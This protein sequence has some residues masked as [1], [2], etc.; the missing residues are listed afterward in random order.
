MPEK[1]FYLLIIFSVVTVLMLIKLAAARIGR[2]R[3]GRRFER[4]IA[5]H[6]RKRAAGQL[7]KNRVKSMLR[8][9][10]YDHRMITDGW[11]S[12]TL[13]TMKS[14]RDC[15]KRTSGKEKKG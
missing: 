12:I 9:I 11:I 2:H 6:L 3:K 10:T 5:E 7:T 13:P 1:D 15:S 4:E 14:L 8:K